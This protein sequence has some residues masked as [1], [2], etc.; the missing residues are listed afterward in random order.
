MVSII[1][2]SYNTRNLLRACLSSVNKILPQKDVEIIVVDNASSDES[3]AM[4][5][6]EFKNV[7]L[8]E[9]S[10]NAGFA[11]GCNLGASYAGGEYLLF[12]NSDTIV[13]SDN[14]SIFLKDFSEN[15]KIA[16]IGGLLKNND[17][18][19][20]RSYGNFY[21]LSRVFSMLFLGEKREISK[22][23]TQKRLIVDWVSGGFMMV[24]RDIFKKIKGFDEKF[25][26]YIEDME[27]CYRAKREGFL[28]LF[29]PLWGVEHVGQGS[30]NR[31]FAI[32]QI[33]KGL[34]IFYRKHL[35]GF[36]LFFLKIMLIIKAAGAIAIGSFTNNSNLRSTY[37]K[38]LQ[39]SL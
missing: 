4:V 38:A 5:K 34:L 24:R 23:D 36:Q 12:L 31:N 33:Y 26:M 29:D 6:K 11:K 28:T 7:R 14:L 25:F 10:E 39:V 8:I 17:G 16:I 1:I 18:S 35:G 30:S 22:I 3:A 32:V 21:T 20:Q 15:T 13:E 19:T 9:N 2:L 27:F 37:R